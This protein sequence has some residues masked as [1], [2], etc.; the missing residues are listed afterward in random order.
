MRIKPLARADSPAPRSAYYLYIGC[1][2]INDVRVITEK[3]EMIR[4]C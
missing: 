3:K 2:K 4:Y 1:K